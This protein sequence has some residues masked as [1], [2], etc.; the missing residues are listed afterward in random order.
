L[1][2]EA[3]KYVSSGFTLC[4]FVVAALFA[5]LRNR[6]QE[7]RKRIESASPEDRA[8]LVAK[9]LEIFSVDTTNLT[10][11]QQFDIAMRQING[12]IEHFRI[13]AVVVVVLAAL[14]AGLSALALAG[15][16]QSDSQ[17]PIAPI[18]GAPVTKTTGEGRPADGTEKT[19]SV[20]RMVLGKS[21][22]IEY[23]YWNG[24]E[25]QAELLPLVTVLTGHDLTIEPA[26]FHH[27]GGDTHDDVR[28]DYV[29]WL[30]ER[31]TAK[32][33]NR[34]RGKQVTFWFEHY[35]QENEIVSD[36]ESE[37]IEFTAW[38]GGH[39]RAKVSAIEIKDAD[40]D[41]IPLY[42]LLSKE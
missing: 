20:K 9:T 7:E 40:N 2:W 1:P 24:E 38:D 31:W 14:G 42:F 16:K 32:I 15:Q 3:I 8:A 25:W 27:V 10:R 17:K 29:S 22:V 6:S 21:E 13:I 41:T 35:K 11:Q 37:A 34:I 12:R 33:H 5:Y 26:S 28:I 39:W 4:A 30:G 23:K 19:S 36:H 18:N